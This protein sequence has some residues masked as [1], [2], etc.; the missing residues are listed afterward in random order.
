[1]PSFRT[2]TVTDVLLERD[3]MQRVLVD[4]E[5][6]YA[7]TELVGPIDVGDFVI[8]NTT[9]VE[10]G[11]GTGGE[12]VVH[13]N[14]SC[15]GW[16]SDSPGHV[17]KLRYASNQLQTRALGSDLSTLEGMPVIVAD[18]H[19]QLAAIAVAF[20][21]ATDAKL[22]YVMTDGGA[23]PLALSD[24]VWELR[25]RDLIDLRITAGN[26]FGGDVEAVS[27]YDA[28]AVAR[29]Q[30]DAVVV[31]MGP[32]SVGTGTTLGFS[33][34]DVGA[35]LNA[36]G[37]LNGQPI[38][39]LRASNADP[40]ERHRGISHHSVTALTLATHVRAAVAVPEGL[41]VDPEIEDRHE[42][43]RVPEC[44]IVAKMHAAGLE[45]ASM[46]RPAADDPIL[47]ECAA[48]AGTVAAQRLP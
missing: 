31:A 45:V 30:A 39:A 24:L 20:K 3:G 36:A 37:A 42:I 23:L 44:G 2:G 47:F 40:R 41:D 28:L 34:I 14:L 4:G 1:M 25:A 32:G 15:D 43:V 18:L 29:E 27:V 7:L 22:A 6:A 33:G 12:H 11:L 8:V 26:A 9:A 5:P 38:A 46:G 21:A 17:M 48:A 16:K 35:A 19:S 10:L 13:W